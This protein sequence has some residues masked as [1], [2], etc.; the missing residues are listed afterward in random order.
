VTPSSPKLEEVGRAPTAL[1]GKETAAS[2]HVAESQVRR[3]VTAGD[4]NALHP[5]VP[6]PRLSL[7]SA[8]GHRRSFS[9]YAG[10][11][12]SRITLVSPPGTKVCIKH[13]SY[14]TKQKSFSIKHMFTFD[15]AVNTLTYRNL[16]YHTVI[17]NC[18]LHIFSSKQQ[19]VFFIPIDSSHYFVQKY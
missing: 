9:G 18:K 1:P 12:E 8:E 11:G 17:V 14:V 5:R 13:F 15:S 10:Y 2:S 4:A 19:C 16:P 6:G 7:H 3:G